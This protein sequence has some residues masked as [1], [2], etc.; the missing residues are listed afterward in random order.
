MVATDLYD[1]E[2]NSNYSNIILNAFPDFYDSRNN[3]FRIGLAS[4]VINL[5]NVDNAALVPFD[6]LGISR[7][8]NPDLGAYQA[9]EKVE[10]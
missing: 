6:I 7:I 9:Q 3:N 4:E 5:G 2:N 8:D 10:E 1:F